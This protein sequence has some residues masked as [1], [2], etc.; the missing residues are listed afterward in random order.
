[1]EKFTRS[2]VTTVAQVGKVEVVDGQVTAPFLGEIVLAG[3]ADDAKIIR[4][5]RESYGKD[6]QMVVLSK[7]EKIDKYE[8]PL[9]VFL[10]NAT[11]I[12]ETPKTETETV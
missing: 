4:K 11:L 12:E 2:I 8:M 9:E 10:A 7:V 1:M 5:A 6:N 3:K